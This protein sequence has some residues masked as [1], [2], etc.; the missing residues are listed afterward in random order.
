MH[1]CGAPG[2]DRLTRLASVPREELARRVGLPLLRPTLLVTF[3]PVTLEPG[4][5]ERQVGQLAD[6]LEAVKGTVIITYPGADVGYRAVIGRLEAL[7]T[8]RPETRMAIGLGEDGVVAAARGGRDD[9]QLLER[10][11]RGAIFGLPV[12]NVG[13]RQRGRLRAANIIDVEPARDEIVAG[14]RRAVD[15][16]FRA[17]L[18]GLVNPYGDGHAAP[19]HRQGPRRGRAGPR[20]AP[21]ASRR[22][23]IA[24]LA[25]RKG[26][27]KVT[28][29]LI[30]AALQRGHEAVLLRDPGEQKPGEV[31]TRE[32]LSHWPVARVVDHRWGEPL[33]PLLRAQRVSALLVG[34]CST[35]F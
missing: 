17:S 32:D 3:H 35:S 10:P 26:F 15:P 5:T 34:P 16:A 25:S 23:K 30:Q 28:G 21:E 29:S 14:I 6:A 27:L 18:A 1:C 19:P 9:R 33:L 8:S 7:A 4:E 2:L 12:V 31:A 20:P 22:L 24:F 13:S 11:H